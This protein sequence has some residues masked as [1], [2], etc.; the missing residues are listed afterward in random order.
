ME[1]CCCCCC[2]CWVKWTTS[3]WTTR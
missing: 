3:S 1:C 2:C